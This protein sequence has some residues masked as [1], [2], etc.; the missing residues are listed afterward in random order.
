MIANADHILATTRAAGQGLAGGFTIG[1][2]SSVSAGNLRATLISALNKNPEVEIE[3]VEA[4]GSVLFAGLDSGE[5]DIA[6]LMGEVDRE[7]FRHAPFWSEHVYVAM[8]SSHKLSGRDVVYWM[9]LREQRFVLPSA[10]P[11]P[12]I[13]DMLIGRLWQSGARPDIVLHPVSR[14]TILSI[15]G[16]T[17]MLSVACEGTTGAIYPD[18]IYR[19]IQGEQGPALVPYSGYWREDN[20]NPALKRF[21]AFVRKRYALSFEINTPTTEN[22]QTSG[23][24][25]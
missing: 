7:G 19:P 8:S 14:E 25:P 1:F 16:D 6:I 13:R 5:I 10:D 3:Q 15:L 4:G 11:G 9:D 17:S 12:E 20:A 18:V 2:N 22:I 24:A 21:L 23:E